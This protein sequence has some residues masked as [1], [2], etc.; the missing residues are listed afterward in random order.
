MRWLVLIP[1]ILLPAGAGAWIAFDKYEKLSQIASETRV[2]L[3]SGSDGSSSNDDGRTYGDFYTIEGIVV[4]PA[5]SQGK[6]F[7]LID[8]AMETSSA[9]VIAELDDKN[10][11]IRDS[12]LKVL[13]SQTV[14]DL[15]ALD[16]RTILKEDIRDAVNRILGQGKV[17]HL[18]FTQFVLQ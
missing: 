8:I 9:N 10:V 1:L 13:A 6:R 11:V 3:T 4:N 17:D 2:R 12:I 5:E 18:Y 15:S 16:K 7:L 14:A